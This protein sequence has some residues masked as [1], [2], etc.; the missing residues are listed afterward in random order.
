MK[1]LTQI[2]TVLIALNVVIANAGLAQASAEEELARAA[3]TLAQKQAELAEKAAS[4]AERAAEAQRSGQLATVQ[5]KVQ[6]DLSSLLEA[7]VSRALAQTRGGDGVLMVLTAEM[8]PEDLA[9]IT[10]DLHIMSRI[11]DKNLGRAR[12]TR[13][14]S[15]EYVFK[16]FANILR[17]QQG[18]AETQAMYVQ[19]YGALFLMNVDFPLL[20]PAK[21]E[22]AKVEPDI[23]PV[24]EQTKRQFLASGGEGLGL[25]YIHERDLVARQYDSEKVEDLKTKLI[26]ALKHA[27]NIRN[28]KPDESVILV[29]A[30][31]Q[32]GVVVAEHGDEPH[33]YVYLHS[34][35]ETGIS[36][37]PA[38]TIRAKKSDIDAYAK[39]ELDFEQFR[40]QVQVLTSHARLGPLERGGT[41][42]YRYRSLPQLVLPEEPLG[43]S[44]IR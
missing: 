40:Q 22:P 24:W 35:T 39:G 11:C 3:Q 37:P 6:A 17:Q 33:R 1:A 4:A 18:G 21:V 9:V 10:E 16:Q 23:D 41:E 25:Q 19:S 5:A 31:T 14:R 29:V 13:T 30:G 15:G 26:K 28:L 43:T 42:Y 36:S 8:T 38:L 27:A 2:I 32:P 44:A 7:R 12:P 20:G 34:G